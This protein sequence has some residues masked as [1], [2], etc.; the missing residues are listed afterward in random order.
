ME[1]IA[2]KKTE[3][4]GSSEKERLEIIEK[5][6]D[7][8]KKKIELKKEKLNTD[9]IVLRRKISAEEQTLLIDKISQLRCVLADWTIDDERTIMASEPFLKPL[10]SDRNRLIVTNKLIELINKL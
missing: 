1:N 9:E 5:K 7:I 10:I 6:V 8:Q 4:S 3:A 2:I